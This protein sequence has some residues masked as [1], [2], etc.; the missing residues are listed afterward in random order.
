M[1]GKPS[2]WV[3]VTVA[4]FQG[5]RRSYN[6]DTIGGCQSL[7]RPALPPKPNFLVEMT[8]SFARGV[9]K[10]RA[11]SEA[12]E[13]RALVAF[14][15]PL[16]QCQASS[17]IKCRFKGKERGALA[18]AALYLGAP[19]YSRPPAVWSP[20]SGS[21]GHPWFLLLLLPLFFFQMAVCNFCWPQFLVFISVY[22]IKILDCSFDDIVQTYI[23]VCVCVFFIH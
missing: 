6:F 22:F 1:T 16:K 4:V 19:N 17:V 2:V 10:A 14:S 3:S 18:A 12:P 15:P 11:P 13:S 21:Q 5:F 9:A 20:H 7:Q 23:C 8:R